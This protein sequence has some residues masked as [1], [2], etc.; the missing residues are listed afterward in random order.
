MAHVEDLVQPRPEQILL[1]FVPQL[2][3]PQEIPPENRSPGAVNPTESAESIC[4]KTHP[5]P[6]ESGKIDYFKTSKIFSLSTRWEFFA[7]DVLCRQELTHWRHSQMHSSAQPARPG[8]ARPV[9]QFSQRL[10]ENG[11]RLWPN[12]QDNPQGLGPP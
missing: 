9:R 3:W 4:K 7:G 11:L 5:K 2:S 8:S 12:E 6:S 10:P 1:A